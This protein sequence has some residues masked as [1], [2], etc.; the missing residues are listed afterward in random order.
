MVM[1]HAE[2]LNMEDA[3]ISK[4]AVTSRYSTARRKKIHANLETRHISSLGSS[5]QIPE[6]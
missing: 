5:L 6:Y 3:A 2:T 4:N 1:H